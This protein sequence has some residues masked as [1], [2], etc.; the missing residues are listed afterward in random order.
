MI[1]AFLTVGQQVLVL[2]I[3]LAIGFTMGKLNVLDDWGVS[4]MSSLLLYIVTPAVLLTSFQREFVAAD[5][6]RFGLVL[7]AA[8]MLQIL[9][10]GGSSLVI[11]DQN[12]ERQRLL[13]FAA[14]F[15]NCGYMGY[16]L[17][18]ALVGKIGIYYGSAYVVA[19]NI[20]TWTYGVYM[21]SGDKKQLRL[22]PLLLNPGVLGTVAA[23]SLY[24]LR[25]KLPDIVMLPLEHI[26]A[27]NTP[28]PM[29]VIGYQLSQTDLKQVFRGFSTLS[30][31]G[32]RLAISPLLSLGVC[33][34]LNLRGDVAIVIM[35]AAST[36]PAALLGLFAVKYKMDAPTAS[37]IVSGFTA[38]S[39]VTMPLFVSLAQYI[40]R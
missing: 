38:M 19:F 40:L 6:Q 35:V 22:R 32:M 33:L 39:V 29:L 30:A 21:I 8:F 17:M 31:M 10:I 36:P 15:S 23:L 26:S 16:P 12:R 25:V 2:F 5:F 1:H 7:L 37:G 34:L 14:V 20:L 9:L 18:Q 27:L 24:L 3:L 28:L 4:G 13:R 11:R